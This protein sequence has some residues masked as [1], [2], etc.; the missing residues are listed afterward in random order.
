MRPKKQLIE[1]VIANGTMDRLNMLLSAAHILKCETNNLYE[2][3]ADLLKQNGMLL[4][5]LKR[6]HNDFVRAADRY[7]KEFSTLIDTEEQKMN[8]FSDIDTFD[9]SFRIWAKL[10]ERPNQQSQLKGCLAAARKSNGK[11][12]MC[13][14]CTYNNSGT[15]QMCLTCR[16]SFIKGFQKGAKW[17]NEK[18]NKDIEIK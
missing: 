6:S 2:E 3:A 7:F 10:K 13:D 5:D 9:N 14:K 8:M 15:M 12:R 1:A 18:S 17:R 11:S 16:Q 4:G